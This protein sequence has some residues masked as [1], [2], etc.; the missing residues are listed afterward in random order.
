[1][2][3]NDDTP[4]DNNNGYQFHRSDVAAF[5]FILSPFTGLVFDASVL[6]CFFASTFW[7]LVALAM[8]Y[9]VR[10]AK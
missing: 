2:I 4:Q 7:G 10:R 5:L 9:K 3:D 1:M 8:G 6:W